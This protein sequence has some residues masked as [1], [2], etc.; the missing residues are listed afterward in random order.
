ETRGTRMTD[1]PPQPPA[2]PEAPAVL[3]KP[4]APSPGELAIKRGVLR[5]VLCSVASLGVYGFYWFHQYRRRVSAELGR[6][7]D[8]GLHTA[9]LLVPFLNYY[10]TY[11]LWRDIGEARRR[12]GLSGLPAGPYVVASVFVAPII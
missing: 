5:C 3:R 10:L 4:P 12:V 1:L 7:D 6:S 2:G 8:A 9:G 11:L